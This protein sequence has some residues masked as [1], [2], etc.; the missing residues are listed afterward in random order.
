MD[1]SRLSLGFHELIVEGKQCDVR[2]KGFRHRRL[3]VIQE[4]IRYIKANKK[5]SR[6]KEKF[7]LSMIKETFFY[8]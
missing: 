2:F 6:V 3:G 4:E 5:F 7:F 8:L 1:K